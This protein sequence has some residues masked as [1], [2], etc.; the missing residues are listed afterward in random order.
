M[1]KFVPQDTTVVF[2]EIPDEICLA[3]NLSCCPHRCPGCH[4]PYLQKDYGVELDEETLDQLLEHN[5]GITC[6]LFMGGDNDKYRLCKLAGHVGLKYGYKTAWYSGEGSLDFYQVGWYFDYIKVG[7]YM[8]D[9]GPINEPTTNQRL[10]KIDKFYNL[11]QI[12]SEDI[13]NKFWKYGS[14]Q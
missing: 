9:L 3:I 6:V 4:S 1:I 5:S 11:N 14:N 8:K 13:T 12:I 7:P 2:A 10:Y